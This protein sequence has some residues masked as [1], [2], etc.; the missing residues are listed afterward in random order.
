MYYNAFKRGFP[1][2]VI[3][4]YILL[5]YF[6]I[7][8]DLRLDFISF[9]A[10]ATAYLK[11]SN[12]YKVLVS[13]FLPTNLVKLPINLNPPF[14]LELIEPLTKLSYRLAT[15]I[16]FFILFI[17]GLIGAYFSFKICVSPQTFKKNWFYLFIIYLGFYSTVISTTI[18]QVGSLLLFFIIGGYYFY[19]RK[20]DYLAGFLW[21]FIITLKI[22]PALLFFFALKQRRYR[23]LMV[24]IITCIITHLIPIIT[25][26]IHI[27]TLYFDMVHRVLWYG[28][29]WNA[30]FYGFLF[31]LLIDSADNHQSLW[32]VHAIYAVI[33]LILLIWYVKKIDRIQ[34][35][36]H[37]SFC[38]TLV[39]MLF[40]SPLGWLYYFPLLIMPFAYL[41]ETLCRQPTLNIHYANLGLISLLL[42]NFPLG[43]VP[44]RD[45]PFI[46][47]KLT[48]LSIYF[49]GLLI[50][51]YLLHKP[52]ANKSTMAAFSTTR[53][54]YLLFPAML[55]LSFGLLVPL[56]IFVAHLL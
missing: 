23:V 17:S 49:Y 16:W 28:D 34:T 51:V 45:M 31:R 6:L 14:F 35:N 27:Y 39:M 10:S 26:G 3:L 55:I 7:R 48:V 36:D 20:N 30:S 21:G 50:L 24:T 53:K 2:F 9:Y 11:H 4:T 29:L 40:M 47:F 46:F 1:F 8:L 5:F 19:L 38:L 42:L 22:F 37:R 18:V 52:L 15:V 33:F 13:N 54:N 32:F 56:V 44:E 41:Y 43:Y 12:P 25:H